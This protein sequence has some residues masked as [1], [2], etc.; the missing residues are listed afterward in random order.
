MFQPQMMLEGR[1]AVAEARRGSR[2]NF[3]QFVT[4]IAVVEIGIH[5]HLA[6]ISNVKYELFF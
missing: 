3:S 6:I 5:F 2:R 4:F 1:D